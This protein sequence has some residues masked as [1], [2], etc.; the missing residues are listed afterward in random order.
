MLNSLRDKG[1]SPSRTAKKPV[2]LLKDDQLHISETHRLIYV[3]L[4]EKHGQAHADAWLEREESKLGHRKL[5]PLTKASALLEPPQ[6]HLQ[7]V[8]DPPKDTPRSPISGFETK[9]ATA[10]PPKAVKGVLTRSEDVERRLQDLPPLGLSPTAHKLYKLCLEVALVVAEARHY[11][12]GVSVVTFFCPQEIM[13]NALGVNRTSIWRNLP[14]LFELGLMDA[15]E[16][17]TTLDGETK[18]AGYLWQVKL[19]PS[20]PHKPRLKLHDFKHQ[21][22]DLKADVR[23]GKTAYN[24]LHPTMQQSLELLGSKEAIEKI[25]IWALNPSDNPPSLD[26]MTVA[27]AFSGGV[28]IVLDVPYTPKTERNEMVD[29]AARAM[30]L[31]LRD[32]SKHLNF[33]R[34]LL[35]NLLRRFDQGQDYFSAI[36]DRLLWSRGDLQ[37]GK[38]R[39]GGA[40]FISRLQGWNGWEEVRRTP[41]YRVGMPP[42][43]A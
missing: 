27:P 31:A 37:E 2:V 21:W 40:L 43:Q 32:T 24:A 12:P 23:Q 34:R 5:P 19:E 26:T 6:P 3:A 35:W 4:V 8:Q 41:P 33:Y 7:V 39:S 17:K 11:S 14:A 9:T 16:W 38:V 13:A 18:N 36:Y 22:R 29:A 10:T 30:A 20:S 28:E 42:L 25:L 1:E 15:G